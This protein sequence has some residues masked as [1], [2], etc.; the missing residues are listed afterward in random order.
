MD[1]TKSEIDT[2]KSEKAGKKREKA[3]KAETDELIS[4]GS[5]SAFEGTEAVDPDELTANAR[6]KDKDE[7]T[8]GNSSGQSN[9]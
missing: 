9:Y 4:D 7:K 3:A 6:K 2:A 8:S 1:S 5:A